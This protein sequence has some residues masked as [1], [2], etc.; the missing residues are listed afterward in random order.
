[1]HGLDFTNFL[2][3]HLSSLSLCLVA[4]SSTVSDAPQLAVGEFTCL[5]NVLAH[6]HPNIQII[7]KNVKQYWPPYQSLMIDQKKTREKFTD[8]IETSSLMHSGYSKVIP[9]VWKLHQWAFHII[10]KTSAVASSL[11]SNI[12]LQKLLEKQNTGR[13]L[14]NVI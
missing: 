11:G 6:A 8:Y 5:L 7:N 2:S 13:T 10:R 9:S 4:L 3:Y 12:Q 14:C 1:M